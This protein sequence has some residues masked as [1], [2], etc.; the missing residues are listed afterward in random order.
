[1]NIHY[2]DQHPEEFKVITNA[3]KGKMKEIW[4][5]HLHENNRNIDTHEVYLQLFEELQYMFRTSY[6]AR[7]DDP[8]ELD[9]SKIAAFVAKTRAYKHGILVKRVGPTF[10]SARTWIRGRVEPLKDMNARNTCWIDTARIVVT[11][12]GQQFDG[13]HFLT[14]TTDDM[15]VHRVSN[16]LIPS[17]LMEDAHEALFNAIT[18]LDGG[19]F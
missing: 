4:G 17:M 14:V 7:L 6:F 10:D 16:Y 13:Q 18:T 3:L 1:M 19:C 2:Y 8:Q 5:S 12:A 11:G 9:D 15:K